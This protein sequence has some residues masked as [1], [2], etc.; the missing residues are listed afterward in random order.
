MILLSRGP[1]NKNSIVAP[2][3]ENTSLLKQVQNAIY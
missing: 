3:L 2:S 1:I